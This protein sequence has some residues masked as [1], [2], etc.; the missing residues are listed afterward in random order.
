MSPS[1]SGRRV[2]A[3]PDKFRGTL[4]AE[5]AAQAIAAGAAQAG[6]ACEELPLA[7]GGE[8]TLEVLGGA[9]RMTWVS[10]PLGIPV[11]APWRLEGTAAVIEMARASGLLLA[12]GRDQ[13][14]PLRASTQGTGELIAAAAGAGARELVV[15]VGGSATTDGGRGALE[16]L[17]GLIP[18]PE[19]G[20]DVRVACDVATEFVDAARVFAPQKGATEPQVLRLAER[21]QTL[22]AAYA[23]R[24][25][26]CVEEL[27]GAGAAGGL[28]GGLAA[29][30]AR[31][32]RGF[33]VVAE[34]VGLDPA[35]VAA[36]LV[37]TGEGMLD[38]TSFAGKV[39]GGVL[40][41]AR[42]YGVDV[43]AVVGA[44]AENTGGRIPHASL[45]ARFGHERAMN[46]TAACVAV[47]VEERLRRTNS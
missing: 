36:D 1:A 47:L 7:D 26:V 31:L 39:V 25:G 21:L 29:A 18:F 43:F 22:A 9:N 5:E 15:A 6:W 32:E 45:V 14:D 38:E 35:L 20:L 19:H 41:R 24:F 4:T 13:N 42:S 28:A 3:A 16:A 46:D 27:A 34:L 33:D 40:E 2:L 12:G 30:G 8:G 37:I 23:E 10:G 11:E 17:A 44:A